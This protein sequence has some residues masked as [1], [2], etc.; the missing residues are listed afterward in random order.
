METTQ[1]RHPFSYTLGPGPYTFLDIF[2]LI[3]PSEINGGKNNFDKAPKGCSIGTCAHCGHGIIYNFII[4]TGE[5]KLFAV[6]S[7][8]IENIGLGGDFTNATV[9]EKRM[10]LETRKRGQEQRERRRIKQAQELFIRI[11]KNKPL[12]MSLQ[13]PSSFHS[14]KTAYDYCL[15]IYRNGHVS[16]GGINILKGKLLTW[17]QA[18]TK[19]IDS[20]K[21]RR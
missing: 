18:A 20:M 2:T 6:G 19:I 10:K 4:K 21:P 12:L 14:T 9:I 17:E 16:I 11:E 15:Y 3:I 8:C 7:D 13:H 5:N 1:K